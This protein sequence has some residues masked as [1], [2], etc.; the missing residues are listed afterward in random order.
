MNKIFNKL[1][2][3]AAV[4][5]LALGFA[6][7]NDILD[8]KPIDFPA[9]GSFWRT[10]TE[11]TS[12]IYANSCMV[13]DQTP[14][15][16][17]WAGELRSGTF[18][19]DLINASGALN[20]DIV[21]NNYDVAHAQFSTFGGWYG[22][23]ANLNELIQQTNKAPEGVLDEKAF[24]GILGIAYGW[25]AFA[26]FQMYRMYGGV[27]L[28][29]EPEVQDGV[30]DPTQL[31]KPRATAEATLT[32][33]KS[34]IS[35]SLKYFALSDWTPNKAKKTY[36][37]SKAATEMLAG[38]VYLWSGKVSTGD[39][40]AN[41]ADVSVAKGYFESVVNNYGYQL[42]KN[43]FSV[44]TTPQNSELIYSICYSSE[45]DKVQFTSYQGQM[46]YAHAGGEYAT[47]GWTN[48]DATGMAIRKDG[49]VSQFNKFTAS[50]TAKPALYTSWNE[51]QPSPN[52][53]M[54]KNAMYYQYS[55]KDIRKQ[56]F[57]PVWK[58]K[59]GEDT[60][61]Y[62]ANFD[63]TQY[64]MAGS[65]TLKFIPSIIPS[66]SATSYVWNNDQ[67]IYRLPLAYMY[68]AE[69]ANYEGNN[70]DVEKY[71]N[72]VRKRAYGDNWDE[73]TD[74]YRAGTFRENEYAI[75]LEKNKEFLM[76]GQRWWDLRRLTV[77]R[78]GSDTDHFVFQPESCPGFGLDPV[79]CPWYVEGDGTPIQTVTPVLPTDQAHKV[80]WPINQALLDSDPEIEQNP[81]Y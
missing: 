63:P 62:I 42:V 10:Q 65:F 12:N 33:I 45:E 1:A 81:G 47:E 76:E 54:Y 15:I 18:T 59:E 69:I 13:R 28:R 20:V 74:A 39:H 11:F 31:Y 78:G 77:V 79:A 67:A 2:S 29:L 61:T 52:R 23:I 56:V 36:Y 50:A 44:W 24:N 27:P 30:T 4:S 70:G 21:N 25:R 17:F 68:L 71:I 46:L 72:L 49:A 14:N 66:W 16:L 51:W 37:W 32:Q 3:V 9:A 64:Q 48:L 58:L 34:D 60:L 6:S 26:Y 75:L 55:D 5:A 8:Q 80:L 7:C 38:E 73:A 43:F 40:Q 22:F 35:E 57:M 53:Y 19:T 41:P